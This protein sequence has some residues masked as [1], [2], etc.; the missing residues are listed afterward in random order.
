MLVQRTSSLCLKCTILAPA[1]VDSNF[2]ISKSCSAVFFWLH[3][4]KQISKFLARDKLE[5]VLHA[6]V[7]SR[8]DY[9]NG[10]L[11][12]LPNC[13]I[14]KLQRVQ[15]AAAR[16]LTSSR[17]FDHIT[18]VLKELYWL[19]VRYRI[20]FKILLLTFK[21]LNGM[22]PAYISDLINVRKHTHYSLR[23]NSGTILLYPAGKMKKIL[24]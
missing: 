7:T 3:N 19:P 23:S 10:L 17:K 24:W 15:N 8:I 14:T 21:A 12:G 6:F 5:I 18:P 1:W 20:H 2:Y 11:Y 13:E 16:L 9:C 22:A 4:I